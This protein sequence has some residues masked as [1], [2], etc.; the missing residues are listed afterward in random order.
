M[1]QSVIHTRQA[2]KEKDA[3]RQQ[4]LTLEDK[5]SSHQEVSR[6]ALTLYP[7]RFCF[8]LPVT[9]SCRMGVMFRRRTIDWI[10][11]QSRGQLTAGYDT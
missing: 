11:L 7:A 4:I 5:A 8:L 1:T 10:S 2:T 9:I 3:L 6:F